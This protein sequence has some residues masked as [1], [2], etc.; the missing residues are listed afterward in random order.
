MP[1]H[2]HPRVLVE[3]SLERVLQ[4]AVFRRSDRHRRFLRY[5]V[6]AALDDQAETIKEVLIG[7]ALF[8]RRL[9]SYD[10][11]TDPI[12]RVEA[13][14]IRA[15]L[16]R[17]YLSEGSADP[18]GFDIPTGGYVPRFARRQAVKSRRMV[19]TYAVLPFSTQDRNTFDFATGLADQVINLLGRASDVRVVARNSSLKV[20]ERNA[21]IKEIAHLLKVTRV[22]DGSIQ[23]QGE[24]LRCIA[25]IYGCADSTQV[26]SQ[27]FD[28]LLLSTQSGQ[29][30]DL[31]AFQDLVAEAIVSAALPTMDAVV[32]PPRSRGGHAPQPVSVAMERESRDRLAQATYLYRRFDPVSCDKVI[33]LAERACALDPQSAASH[34]Q[35]ALAYFQKATLNVARGSAMRPKIDRALGRATDLDPADSEALALHA[36]LTFRFAYDWPMA[37]RLFREALRISPHASSI[38]YRYG[39]CLIL[40]RRFEEGLK[41]LNA[42]VDLNPLDLGIR[43]SAAHLLAYTGDYRN[44]EADARAV[45]NLEPTHIFTNIGLGL[46]LLYQ[47]E[48]AAA[49]EQFD[50]VI[51]LDTDHVFA[52]FGRIASLGFVGDAA[53]GARELEQLLLRL[54]ESYYPRYG[55]AIASLGLGRREDAYR[56][57]GEAAEDCDPTFCSLGTDPLF[58]DCHADQDFIGLLG[59]LGMAGGSG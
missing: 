44:A 28:S 27:S 5:V 18:F 29:P 43:A 47:K 15:K 24:R 12:V 20:R 23:R 2:S 17:Y 7:V 6:Q 4:S 52:V 9:E 41:H 37:E 46:I 16:T 31:F 51:A 32:S 49:L 36:M 8:D 3:A 58:A 14:R 10:P 45:L 34:V 39:F 19:E 40:N 55:L 1:I 57:L 42:A 38:N 35:L 59:R 30:M 21:D 50:R 11:Q 56:A 48:F 26:W 53:R 25:H 22:V 54:G 33:D 13:G